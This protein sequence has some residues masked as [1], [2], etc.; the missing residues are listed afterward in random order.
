M[1]KKPN[2]KV[3]SKS[4]VRS[5]RQVLILEEA[6]VDR[7]RVLGL[8]ALQLHGCRTGRYER[9]AF[10]L[11]NLTPSSPLTQVRRHSDDHC[12]FLSVK[13]TRKRDFPIRQ[14]EINSIGGNC[15]EVCSFL[16][17]TLFIK[18]SRFL[19][20]LRQE[21]TDIFRQPQMWQFGNK[22]FDRN[23]SCAAKPCAT[24]M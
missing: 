15:I 6:A 14:A 24:Q 11:V 2:M 16:H 20:I 18:K 12:Q 21:P 10:A 7:K 8:K 3:R 23:A 4:S 22:Y 13:G 5:T 19:R 17:E 9:A 1:E